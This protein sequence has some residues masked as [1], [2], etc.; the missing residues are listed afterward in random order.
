MDGKS[1]LLLT[2]EALMEFKGFRLGP[3]LKIVGY[4]AHLRAKHRMQNT[5]AVTSIITSQTTTTTTA[6]TTAP[7]TTPTTTTINSSHVLT[8]N[9][10]NSMD[11]TLSS[12][13]DESKTTSVVCNPTD[14]TM[15]TVSDAVQLKEICK[16]RL[17]RRINNCNPEGPSDISQDNV[18]NSSEV[19]ATEANHVQQSATNNHVHGNEAVANQSREATHL[20]TVDTISSV[21]STTMEGGETKRSQNL[22][23]LV[24]NP[25]KLIRTNDP[26][27]IEVLTNINTNI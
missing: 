14:V 13:I 17:T 18:C 7:I 2:R 20:K 3:A 5:A 12:N 23:P 25:F 22:T 15:D 9:G 16:E 6:T 8:P 19:V 10:V 24:D 4:A 27:P 26:L 21:S 11:S 1:F